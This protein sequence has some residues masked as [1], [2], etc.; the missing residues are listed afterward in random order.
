MAISHRQLPLYGL[1]FH[2]EAILTECGLELLSHF[3][4]YN[5]QRSI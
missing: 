2:P 4:E 1:Q 5:Y 3:L